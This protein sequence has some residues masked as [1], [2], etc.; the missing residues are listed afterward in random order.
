MKHFSDPE[1]TEIKARLSIEVVLKHYNAEAEAKEIGDQA[2]R[3]CPLHDDRQPSFSYNTRKQVWKCHSGCGGGDVFSL[4]QAFEDCPFPDAVRKG[5]EISGFSTPEHPI[6]PFVPIRR[7]YLKQVRN[8]IEAG[9]AAL[10]RE[11]CSSADVAC[12]EGDGAAV[13]SAQVIARDCHELL[14]TGNL[15]EKTAHLLESKGVNIEFLLETETEE[16]VI[17][18]LSVALDPSTFEATLGVVQQR[19]ELSRHSSTVFA[20]TPT[21][22]AELEAQKAE[23]LRLAQLLYRGELLQNNADSKRAR[24]YLSDRG[25]SLETCE[26]FGIGYAPPGGNWFAA[27]CEGRGLVDAAIAVGLL[28]NCPVRGLVDLFVDRLMLPF[29][30]GRNA[31]AFTGRAMKADQLPKYKHTTGSKTGRHVYGWQQKQHVAL[32]KTALLVEGQFDV[33]AV[34]SAELPAAYALSGTSLSDAQA[35]TLRM[36]CQQV[37]VALDGDEAGQKGAE[38]VMAKCREWGLRASSLRIKNGMDVADVIQAGGGRSL[39]EAL[40]SRLYD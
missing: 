35:R 19:L 37:L 27:F 40:E 28:K 6:D 24:Q 15:R 39:W 32:N 12:R 9:I 17:D 4:I 7:Q 11:A 20:P 10:F 3:R 29:L 26:A 13:A 21:L 31:T 5:A 16:E 2:V 30:D 25:I 38:K 18:G 1:Q 34:N 36:R 22:D 14:D 33:L 23:T 8:V